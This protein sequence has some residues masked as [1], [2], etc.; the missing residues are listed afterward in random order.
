MSWK[1]FNKNRDV[2]DVTGNDT[3]FR[4]NTVT[5][6]VC[7]KSDVIDVILKKPHNYW[8]VCQKSDVIDVIDVIPKNTQNYRKSLRKK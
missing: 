5:E 1:I 2:S 6:I 4:K 7:E 8:K 3:G